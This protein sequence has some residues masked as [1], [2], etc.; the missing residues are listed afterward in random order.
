MPNSAMPKKRL[1]GTK[2]NTFDHLTNMYTYVKKLF[3]NSHNFCQ[4][5]H[6]DY[7]KILKIANVRDMAGNACAHT[8]VLVY[9]SLSSILTVF[10]YSRWI[11][12]QKY[13][14]FSFFFTAVYIFVNRPCVLNLVT[15]GR[16]FD[17]INPLHDGRIRHCK[18]ANLI[19][20]N[21][22]QNIFRYIFKIHSLDIWHTDIYYKLNHKYERHLVNDFWMTI[23]CCIY[24]SLFFKIV[25]LKK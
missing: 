11:F 12:R 22:T 2:F 7:L 18:C 8:S 24:R 1:I 9:L 10:N 21:K 4:K 5:T 16:F 13:W 19:F 23:F 20:Y 3:R 15:I 17:L 6:Y 25:S 14:K